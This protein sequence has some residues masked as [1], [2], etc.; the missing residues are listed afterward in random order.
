MARRERAVNRPTP[1][2]IRYGNITVQRMIHLVM[3]RGKK[4][5]AAS[6]VYGAFD[7]VQERSKREP[8]EIFEEALK[9]V[10]PSVEVKPRRVG[11]ATYQVPVEV[12]SERRESLAMRW[13]IAASRA[14]GG[15]SMREKLAGELLDAA[16]NTGAAV[17]RR[18]EVHKM[19]EANR[20]FAHYRW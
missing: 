8:M 2:D 13:L 10:G 4:S 17:K 11:G 18:E 5:T 1:P 16:G 9:N 19:A 12:E 6:I 20:A 3:R 14:R 7:L 15:K